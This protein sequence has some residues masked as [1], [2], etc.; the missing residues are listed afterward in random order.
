LMIQQM[1]K[2]KLLNKNGLLFFVFMMS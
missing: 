1:I 2:P